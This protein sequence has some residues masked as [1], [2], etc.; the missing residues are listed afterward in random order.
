MSSLITTADHPDK[1][2]KRVPCLGCGTPM[3]TD[4]CHRICKKCQR[5]NNAT[6]MTRVYPTALP[7]GACLAEEEGGAGLTFLFSSPRPC[8]SPMAGPPCGRSGD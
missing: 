5:R 6:P 3:W 1:V 8:R 4:R 7:R 2:K